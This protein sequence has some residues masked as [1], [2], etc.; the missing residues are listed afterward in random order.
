MPM[1]NVNGINISYRIEGEGEPL[2]MIS[3]AGANKGTWRSQ[4]GAFKKYFRTITFDNR[5]VG[6]SDKS[7]RP[8]T[9]KMMAGDTIG[10]MDHLHV[11]RA[12]V[13]GVSMGGMIAQEIAINHP[14]RV[15]KLILACTFARND[16]TSGWFSEFDK[17]IE[18]FARSSRDTAGQRRLANVIMDLQINKRAN[19]IFILPLIKVAIR[20]LPIKF[21]STGPS[22]DAQFAAVR[23]HEY[24]ADRLGMIK[25]PTLVITGAEDRLIKPTSSEVIASLV[26]GAK[27][28][29]VPGGGHSIHVE[30]SGEF[31]RE[32]L[33]FLIN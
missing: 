14:E 33:E 3:G 2:I 6:E 28:V 26:P 31:N 5:G 20:F 10:L 1:A 32:V 29:K 21:L 16:E 30:M 7:A 24:A 4:T 22:I 19:R 11:E 8:Y 13:L 27:L 12:H 25:A 15:N 17:A 18:A 23:T 9:L